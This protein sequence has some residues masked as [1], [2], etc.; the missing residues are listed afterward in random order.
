MSRSIRGSLAVEAA[1]VF[2]FIA[3]VLFVLLQSGT[4]LT[5]QLLSRTLCRQGVMVFAEALRRGEGSASAAVLTEEVLDRKLEALNPESPDEVQISCWKSLLGLRIRVRIKGK[6]GFLYAKAF[7]VSESGEFR[8]PRDVRDA[9]CQVREL[10]E[11]IPEITQLI[12][13]LEGVLGP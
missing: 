12:S 1:L 9:V 6:A 13:E 2:P 10:G 5:G 8:R 4:V 7:S 3:V 11:R